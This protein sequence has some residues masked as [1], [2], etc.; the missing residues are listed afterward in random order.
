MIST[1]KALYE[2]FAGFGI[3]AYQAQLVPKEAVL[4]YLTYSLSE[5]EWSR[6]STFYVNVYYRNEKS[7][8]DALQKADEI[9]AAI[10][11]GIRLRCDGGLIV[12]WPGTPLIQPLPSD[13]DVQGAYIN[14]SINAYHMPGI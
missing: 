2:F 5:P 1:A 9:A 4:P 6:Q 3:P 8:F 13:G 10:G 12:I 14:L 11:E 7:N